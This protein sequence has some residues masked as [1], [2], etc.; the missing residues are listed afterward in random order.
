MDPF[1]DHETFRGSLVA[2]LKRQLFGPS[3]SD[4]ESQQHETLSISPLQIYATGVLFPQKLRQEMLEDSGDEATPDEEADIDGEFGPTHEIDNCRDRLSDSDSDASSVEREPLNLANEFSPSAAGISFRLRR[5]VR[6]AFRVTYGT[7]CPVKISEPHPRAGAVGVDGSIFPAT[8]KVPGFQRT[9]HDKTFE[10]EPEDRIGSLHPIDIDERG[11]KLHITVRRRNDGTTVMSAMLVNHLP[12]RGT[13]APSAEDVYFQVS[14]SARALDGRPVFLPIDRELGRASSDTEL[15]SMDL[16]YRHRRAFAL[17]HGAAGDWN[18]DESLSEEG[19]TDFVRMTAI[20]TYDLKP[21]RPRERAFRVGS[22]LRLSMNFLFNGGDDPNPTANILS[23]LRTLADDYLTWIEEQEKAINTFS[24]DFSAI[25]EQNLHDCRKCHARISRGIEIL[26]RNPQ[27]MTAFRLMNRAMLV[28]QHHSRLP[29]RPVGSG[30][31]DLKYGEKSQWRPFQLAFILMNIA[32]MSS[33]DEPERKIVDLIWF[34]TGGGK[35][36]AYLGLAAFTIC[37]ERLKGGLPGL[38]VLMRYTLR[39]LTAQQF[40]RASALVLAL[41]TLRLDRTLGADL[42]DKEI[43]IGLWVGQSLSP[44]TRDRARAALGR[45][46]QDRYVQNPFQ[47]L[48][49]PWCGADFTDR[50]KLGYR[51]M[52]PVS[53]GSRTVR[54]VCPDEACRFGANSKGLPIFVID[55]DIYESPPTILIGTVDKF[56]Q[57]AW[58]DRVGRL[59]GL[60]TSAQP[61]ALVIQ[62]ELHLISGPLGTIVG[63]YE[64]AI[65]RLCGR[66]GHVHKIVASTATIRRSHEQCW[67]LYAR[68]SFEF[69]PQAIRAGESYFAYED[70]RSP[71]RLYVGFMGNAVKSHQTALVRACSPLLQG[72]CHQIGEDEEDKRAIAD[73]YGTL[74]W[75]FNSLRE[76]GHAVTLCVGDIP[77]FLKGLCHR[78]GV[79]YENRRYIREIVELTSRRNAE[80]IPSILQ[81]LEIPWRMRPSGQPPVDVLLATNMIAVG[82]DVSRLGLIVMSGQPKGTSEYI[83]ASS[84][85]GR[86]F[87][88]LVIT[89]YA[90]SKSRDRSHYERFVAYHQSLYRYVEPTSVTP[91]SPQA[92]DRGLRGV[93][94]ALARQL[95]GI[96]QPNKI[97]DH[98]LK[99]NKEVES[100]LK[101]ANLVDSDEVDEARAEL[102]EWIAFW[103][104][105]RPP[106]YGRMGGKVNEQTLA[107]PFG[108][109]PDPDFQ[110]DAWP[111]L[112]SMRNVDG[113]AVGRVLNIYEHQPDGGDE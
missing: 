91:F 75:Y 74:V 6:L 106:E 61:P 103:R 88:G 98:I 78:L 14:L 83:Q 77:E 19:Y 80:E 11:L 13:T 36:E 86:S 68:E 17:G 24:E 105:Y 97:N 23:A 112:T 93:L 94:I 63:L 81:Q 113:T 38:T 10:V 30:Y 48:Q 72:V 41:E 50:S 42:G 3:E 15:A 12:A 70:R 102:R 96:D 39:L 25:A 92:R 60:G 47:V 1:A 84:R 65:D 51:E 56:A 79:P 18:R 76:L 45:M 2:N 109:V 8:R 100:I 43:S 107:Y 66:D 99:L 16:L 104:Q 29:V 20:P 7:Y 89:V 90:Q 62:D 54:F 52:R 33:L 69:P 108:A 37:L 40:Q 110:R 31:P 95:A 57:I 64:T 34:P 55:E 27:T 87:P 49:C 26:E 73:P 111:L 28:Q 21:I 85:V 53:G 5:P 32:S 46:R 58:D 101:R 71:G 9:H 22:N 67:D 35:T 4:E 82:V 59:F 44:N